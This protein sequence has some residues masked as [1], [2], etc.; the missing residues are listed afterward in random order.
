M[1]FKLR[2]L[3]VTTLLAATCLVVIQ[4]LDN[5]HVIWFFSCAYPGVIAGSISRLKFDSSHGA[6]ITSIVV[7]SMAVS[8]IFLAGCSIYFSSNVLASAAF[9]GGV[10]FGLLPSL[11]AILFYSVVAGAYELT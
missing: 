10:V 1:K 2:S 9:F 6:A 3:F 4:N 5:L 8:A 11:P 7:T